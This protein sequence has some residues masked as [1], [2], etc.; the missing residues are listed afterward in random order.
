[1]TTFVIHPPIHSSPTAVFLSG[2]VRAGLHP[3]TSRQLIPGITT[4]FQQFQFPQ[5]YVWQEYLTWRTCELPKLISTGMR[6]CPSFNA[7]CSSSS[8][9]VKSEAEIISICLFTRFTQILAGLCFDLHKPVNTI[10]TAHSF[11]SS[12]SGDCAAF[13]DFLSA[14]EG[15]RSCS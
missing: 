8:G 3:W 14:A 6:V 12:L 10:L 4:H 13:C 7:I 5:M 15:N 11:K 9:P 2:V 1:M